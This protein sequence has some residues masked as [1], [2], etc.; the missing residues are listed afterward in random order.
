[1]NNWAGNH[2]YRSVEIHRPERIEKVQD[3]VRRTERLKVLGTRHSFNDVA[4]TTGT[5][6]SLDHMNQVISLDG[7]AETVTVEAGINYGQ[8]C[9]WLHR[10]G[11]ALHNLAS[12][13]HISIAGACSTA[14]H[15]SG[16]RNGNLATAVSALDVVIADGDIVALSREQDPDRFAGVVV[17][18][19]GLGIV[20]R[21]TLDLQPA[22]DVRQ[23]VFEDVSL[24][25]LLDHFDD[26]MAKGYSVSPF[27]DWISQRFR[28]WVKER[29]PQDGADSIP[30][31][32]GSKVAARS[33]HPVEGEPADGCTEQRSRPGPWHERL[34]HFRMDAVPS[35]GAELQSE[36]FVSRANARQALLAVDGLRQ[37]I[38]PLLFVSEIRSIAA[39]DLWLSPCYEQDSIALHFTWKPDWEQVRQLLPILEAELAPFEPRPHWGKLFTIPV[40]E[41]QSS[42]ER[43]DDFRGLLSQY[44]PDGKFR[45]RFLDEWHRGVP[46]DDR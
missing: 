25:N 27:T 8:L 42:Y 22:F 23:H 12:L 15:G 7:S 43:L 40:D 5:H 21:L 2:H 28:V 9:P 34:P 14:T 6:I 19:G 45:N 20:T 33:L 11:W 30:D 17:A 26:V 3:L 41:L 29:I 4:D 46:F 44:D 36:Y 38:G 18:L 31:L 10:Q 32:L 13:P 1:V 35:V 16:D 39:D 24:T 37:Q